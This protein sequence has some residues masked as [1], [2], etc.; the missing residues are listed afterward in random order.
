MIYTQK[1]FENIFSFLPNFLEIKTAFTLTLSALVFTIPIMIFSF[2]QVSILAPFS[3]IAVTW[4]IPLAMLF[5]FISVI[6]HF[7]YPLG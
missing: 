2:G 4:T 3:N 7:V 5:G 6:V 1:F